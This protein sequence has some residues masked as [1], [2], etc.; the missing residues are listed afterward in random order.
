MSTATPTINQL[1]TPN[2]WRLRPGYSSEGD[3]DFE[4]MH[5][6]IGQFLADRHSPDPLPDTSLLIENAKFQWGYGKP[7]EKVINSQ[8]DLEFLM[9]HPCLFRNAIAI[10]EPW[11]HVGQNPLGEDVRASLNVAYIAQKIAD[12]DSILFPV[13]SSGLFDPD[14]VVPL[15]TSGLAVVVEGGDPSVRDASTFE[16]GKCSLNDLHCL[17]EKLLISRSPTSALALFICLGHQLAA[18]GHINLIKRAV[19]QVLSLEYLPRDRNGKMLKALK[20]VCQQIETVGSSLKITKRNGHIIAE[21]WDHPEF[22]VGPNEHKEVGERRLHHYQ[23]PDGDA[24]DIP[25]ELIS[26]HEITAD[27]YEGVIDTAI[28][29]EREVNI[30]MFHSD[31]VNEEAILF[32]NWAYRLLHDVIIPHRSILAG[33]RLAWLLKLPDA[34]EILCSTTIDDEIVTECSATCIIYKDFE[35][36][37]IRRSFTCQFHPELLSDLRT[38]GTCEPPTY[39]RLKIDDG[40]RLFARLLYEGMQE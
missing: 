16:G 38:V 3:S 6:L 11:E 30:A 40:A 12:C 19:Q 2:N 37:Q 39:A 14:V 36:K 28:E 18:Q 8:S 29:Y 5:I 26:T 1:V 17:V 7:L 34:I 23:S 13:W 10:I 22:A 33:S 25:Q 20:R 21:G 31:E 4:S 24:L 9:K 32:A 27:E 35:S 15:I